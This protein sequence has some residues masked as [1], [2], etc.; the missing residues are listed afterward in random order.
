MTIEVW[1][2]NQY[3]KLEKFSQAYIPITYITKLSIPLADAGLK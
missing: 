2:N 1:Q 3:N